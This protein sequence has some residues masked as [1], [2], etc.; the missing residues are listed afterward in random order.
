[1]EE[2]SVQTGLNISPPLPESVKIENKEE[3][4][5]LSLKSDNKPKYILLEKT[6]SLYT[7]MHPLLMQFPANARF[8]TGKNIEE[9]ILECIK[10]LILQNYQNTD[11]ERKKII[12]EFI[13]QIHLLG[14][15]IEQAVIFRYIPLQKGEQV[16]TLT[17]E[18]QAIANARYSNLDKK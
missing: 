2:K 13:S 4:S 8:T 1:M 12:L 9:A 17:K 5:N 7:L 16:E 3:L 10:L 15:L 6:K 11:I 14:I 18:L